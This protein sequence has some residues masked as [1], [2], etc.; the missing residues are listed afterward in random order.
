[1]M[2]EEHPSHSDDDSVVEQSPG[3]TVVATGSG[4]QLVRLLVVVG[5][6]TWASSLGGAF[7]Y[8]DLD[9]IVGNPH[10]RQIWPIWEVFRAPPQSPLAGRPVVSLSIAITYALGG[11]NPWAHHAFNMAVHVLNGLLLFEIVRRTLESTGLHERFGTSAARLSCIAAL[12]WMVHPLQSES[13]TYLTQRT[14]LLVS[15]FYLLTLYC[16]IRSWAATDARRWSLAAVAACALG[17]CSKEVMVSAPLAVLLYDRAFQSG[18]IGRAVQRHAVLYAGLGATWL[19]LT[20]IVTT[21]PR[22]A[23]VGFQLGISSLDYLR[24]QMGVIVHYL[25]LSIWPHPLV[26][27]YSDWPIARSFGDVVPQMLLVLLLAGATIVGLIRNA[28]VG[29]LGA[30]FF[31]ILAPSSSFVPIVT[32]IAAE[33]RMYLPL[34][35]IVVLVVVGGYRVM[36][37]LD[38]RIMARAGAQ[39]GALAAVVLVVLVLAGGTIRRNMLFWSTLDIWQ[40]NVIHR[41]ADAFARTQLGAE[42]LRNKDPVRAMRELEEAVRLK[43]DYGLAHLNLGA[44]LFMQRD[45]QGAEKEFS[46]ALRIDPNS[47]PAHTNMGMAMMKQGRREDAISHF[48]DAARI[49]PNRANVHTNLGG[50]L[51]EA[52]RVD[53]GIDELKESLRLRPDREVHAY[54]ASLLT[55]RG[56]HDEAA[57]HAREAQR[58]Q[59]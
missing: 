47:E 44:S 12:I 13:V 32:E 30:F 38:D 53:E 22:S 59:R 41:P 58:L 3:P 16:S 42:L 29:F 33:R 48:R 23:A 31:M 54:L 40:D 6:V 21:S 18:S 24:T 37:W 9:A 8:D 34:A 28:W 25:R 11:L 1:M 43:P 39:R 19:I 49:A 55:D 14:E 4:S 20:A 52:R 5:L 2:L 46:A 50:A 57:V 45:F 26:L 56:R 35:A 27:S 51:I 15:C 10:I 7:I 36:L 17:M